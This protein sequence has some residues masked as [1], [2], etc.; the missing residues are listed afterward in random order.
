[1]VWASEDDTRAFAAQLASHPAIGN[2]FIELHGDLGAGKTTL[3]CGTCCAH[4]ACRDASRAPPTPWSSRTR[5]R[6]LADLAFR[7]LPLQ[8]S[9]RMGR[10][11]LS[12]HLRGP[13]ASS[14]RNG[15]RTP[16]GL[17]PPA[18]LVVRIDA[19]ARRNAPCD[20]E[21]ARRRAGPGTARDEAG[22]TSCARAALVLLL[23]TQQIARGATIVAVRVW[24]APD[25]TRVTI[26][27]DAQLQLQAGRDRPIRRAWRWTSR[28]LELSPALREL[29]AKVRADDPFIAGIRVGQHAPGVVRLV[30]DLKQPAVP[31]VFTLHAG[32]RLPAPAGVRLLSGQGSR[33]AGGAD[34]RADAGTGRSAPPTPGERPAGRPDRAAAQLQPRAT[35][36]R[37]TGARA[38]RRPTA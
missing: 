14:W 16:R 37:R 10:R 30:V 4:W 8:R 2:A 32:G 31:Q 33:S 29:V 20:A 27:S 26:E 3:S 19:Q 13:R 15:R 28:A 25:Y 12:R 6:G 18:D 1:M 5:L 35:P 22:A 9:A 17:L 38:G 34:R 11:G 21:G 23:G 24:P 36:G 7:F